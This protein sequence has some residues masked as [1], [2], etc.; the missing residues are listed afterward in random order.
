MVCDKH[1]LPGIQHM[2]CPE[3]IKEDQATDKAITDPSVVWCGQDAGSSTEMCGDCQFREKA[4]IQESPGVFKEIDHWRC[5]AFDY[6]V[7]LEYAP[8][9]VN[10]RPIVSRCQRPNFSSCSG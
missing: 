3:C 4:R 7:S 5:T 8:K 1:N 2:T 9:P 10:Q 6:S